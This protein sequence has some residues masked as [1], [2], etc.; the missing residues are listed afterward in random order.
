M[1][2]GDTSYRG[3]LKEALAERQG[4]NP[5]YSLR[6]FARDL[7][8][9]PSRLSEV[10]NARRGLS[11]E[12]AERIAVKL[13]L[14]AQEREQFVLMVDGTHARSRA[15]REAATQDLAQRRTETQVQAQTLSL[16]AFHLISDWY[17]YAILELC[18]C[19]DF[20]PR[21]SWIAERL[22]ITPNET[23]L[24][25]ERLQRL[26]LLEITGDK[27]KVRDDVTLSPAGVPSEA[28]KKFHRQILAKA[29]QALAFQS[30]D[31]RDF[32]AITMAIDAG[33]LPEAKALLK[34]FRREFAE[35]LSSGSTT[36]DRV[37]NLSLQF[38]ALDRASPSDSRSHP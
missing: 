26:G 17:H 1:F 8:I 6:S 19:A 36:K 27:W 3:I 29:D 33:R 30:L 7:G 15:R 35:L 22:A 2:T 18:S 5:A 20:E 4:R 21:L 38:F 11:S 13:G 9:A 23:E 25:V 32:S 12:A 24:A 10:L 37:Y 14:N 31:E 34:K 16:D 28:V